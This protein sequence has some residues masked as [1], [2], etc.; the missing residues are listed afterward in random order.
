ML[1]VKAPAKINW[2]LFVLD[3]RQD[4]YHNILSLMQCIGLYDVIEF[5]LSDTIT[6]Y[7]SLDLPN[8]Q[9]LVFKAAS[10]LKNYSGLNIGARIRLV[11][12][13]PSGAGLGGGSS[14]AAYTLMA[15]NELWNMRLGKDQLKALGASLGSDVPFFF[16]GPLALAEGRGEQLSSLPAA[17]ACVLLL[18]KVDCSVPTSWAYGALDSARPAQIRPSNVTAKKESIELIYRALASGDISGLAANMHNDFE[19]AVLQRYPV[20]GSVKERILK[21]GAVAALMSGS[22]SSVFGLFNDEGMALEAASHFP[23][24]FC[25]VV[26]TLTKND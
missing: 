10:L 15:L 21:S 11:K 22:G 19:D 13:I 12:E 14:D 9:N 2:S 6:L 4:G 1:T 20:I 18:V 25:R 16:E 24:Y 8:E 7:S 26:K 3:K 23:F 17:V 5:E